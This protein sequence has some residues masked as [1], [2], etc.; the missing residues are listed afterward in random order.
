[1]LCVCLVC[2]VCVLSVCQHFFCPRYYA[3]PTI[4]RLILDEGLARKAIRQ[5]G[6]AASGSSAS[7]RMIANA[8]GGLLPSLAEEMQAAFHCVILPGYGMR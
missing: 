7:L 3:S 6:G 5:V 2:L 4:H 8:A 1:M